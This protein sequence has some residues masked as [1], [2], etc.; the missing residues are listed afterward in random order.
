MTCHQFVRTD[1]PEVQKIHE[2]WKSGKP[3]VWKR[4]HNL[5]GHVLFPHMLHVR[6]GLSCSVCHGKVEEMD[7]A[8]KVRDMDMGWCVSCHRDVR[9]FV[10]D[11]NKR[12]K[13]G[14]PEPKVRRAPLDCWACHKP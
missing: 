6:A 7:I 8:V 13:L 2:Y 5:P 1:S 14:V 4:V 10:A 12:E 9:K 3:I 11:L